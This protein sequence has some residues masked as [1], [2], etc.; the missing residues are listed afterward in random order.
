MAPDHA[1]AVRILETTSVHVCQGTHPHLY[2]HDDQDVCICTRI[3]VYAYKHVCKC[4]G[5]D[6]NR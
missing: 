1:P 3:C 6:H 2:T 4:I 5:I